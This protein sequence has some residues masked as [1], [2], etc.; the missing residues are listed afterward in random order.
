[1]EIFVV[2]TLDAATSLLIMIPVSFPQGCMFL[3]PILGLAI[4][5]NTKEKYRVT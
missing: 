2:L 1:M 4:T 3:P 5:K